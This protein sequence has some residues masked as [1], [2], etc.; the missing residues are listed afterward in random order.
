MKK[1][2]HLRT[3]ALMLSGIIALS[4]ISG[5]GMNAFAKENESVEETAYEIEYDED[6]TPIITY[7]DED[8]IQVRP[9]AD[10]SGTYAS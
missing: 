7:S 8:E 3:L 5:L 2:K 10:S 4:D 9:P 6:E 1:Q